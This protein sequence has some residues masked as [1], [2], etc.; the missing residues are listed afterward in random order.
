[1]IKSNKNK[2]LKISTKMN[3][4]EKLFKEISKAMLDNFSYSKMTRFPITPAN[5]RDYLIIQK[6]ITKKEANR[7]TLD[8]LYNQ[9]CFSEKEMFE[10]KEYLED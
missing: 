2:D 5:Y 6:G 9:E 7:M 4:D 1:M 10:I 8:L 3:F